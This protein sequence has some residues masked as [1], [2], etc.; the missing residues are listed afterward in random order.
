MKSRCNKMDTEPIPLQRFFSHWRQSEK[1][2]LT[3]NNRIEITH[4]ITAIIVVVI[5]VA[6]CERTIITKT[7]MS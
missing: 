7:K 2:S 1:K 6:H 4:K 3:M 5:T